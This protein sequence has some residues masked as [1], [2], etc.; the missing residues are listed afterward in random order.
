MRPREAYL[1]PGGERGVRRGG[2]RSIDSPDLTRLIFLRGI[3]RSRHPGR[4]KR[5]NG[6]L[7]SKAHEGERLKYLKFI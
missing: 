6:S 1:L 4:G 3:P 7:A 2:V 5:G